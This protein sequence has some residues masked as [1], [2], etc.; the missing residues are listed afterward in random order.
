MVKRTWRWSGLACVLALVA[1]CGGGSSGNNDQGIVFRAAGVFRS[2]TNIAGGEITCTEP[3]VAEGAIADTEGTISLST[4]RFFPDEFDPEGDPCGGQLG[5]RNS[6][7]TQSINVQFVTIEYEVA[8]SAVQVP[9][10]VFN[11]GLT[12]PPSTCEGCTSSGE[13][14][15]TYLSLLGQIVP[16]SRVT[17]LNQ[18]VNRLPAT[19]YQMDVFITASGQSDQGTNYETN[20]TGYTI[21]VT[22]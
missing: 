17:F 19:P 10:Y 3:L 9:R 15:F 16:Q 12:I 20:V 2:L 22:E 18:N 1:G 11:T 7:S 6:L 8:G 14:G 5:L 4:T 13:D 21:T